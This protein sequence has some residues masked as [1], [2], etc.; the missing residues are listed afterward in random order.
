MYQREIFPACSHQYNRLSSP[1][2]EMNTSFL[3]GQDVI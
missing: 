1:L 2:S 3:T